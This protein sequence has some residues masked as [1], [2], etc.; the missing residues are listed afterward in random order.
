MIAIATHTRFECVLP[1]V[2]RAD[3]RK[4]TM[5]IRSGLLFG[6]QYKT[7][8]VVV[9]LFVVCD[10]KKCVC[11][12][13]AYIWLQNIFLIYI[14]RLSLCS[15][16]VSERERDYITFTYRFFVMFLRACTHSQKKTHIIIMRIEN[17]YKYGYTK[18]RHPRW[19]NAGQLDFLI[20]ILCVFVCMWNFSKCFS[21]QNCDLFVVCLAVCVGV[22]KCVEQICVCL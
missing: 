18:T 6:V 12:L 8:F 3:C 15:R 9:C 7:Y 17:I 4:V 5:Y 14:C 2:A 22:C 20:S 19:H 13:Y 10:Y 11:V 21:Y 1:L 16:W